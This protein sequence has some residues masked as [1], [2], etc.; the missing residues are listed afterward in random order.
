MKPPRP[1]LFAVLAVSFAVTACATPPPDFHTYRLGEVPPS[2]R[3]AK[4]K[5]HHPQ[6]Q[7]KGQNTT[8]SASRQK[9]PQTVPQK[10]PLV[11]W[12]MFKP[13]SQPTPASNKRSV[14]QNT[15]ARPTP[16][17]NKRAV[18][19][20]SKTKPAPAPT[21]A[22][23]AQNTKAR[24]QP[25]P[26]LVTTKRAV[27]G[28][29]QPQPA[30]TPSRQQPVAKNSRTST[31]P[32]AAQNPQPPARRDHPERAQARSAAALKYPTAKKTMQDGYVTS[33]YTH[34]KINV[35]RVP[36]GAQV[37]DPSSEKVFINP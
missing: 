18:T 10:Q 4:A 28:N 36:H 32:I 5:K 22:A 13:E 23:V 7:H 24:P 34:A 12:W 11:R 25:T 29:K 14:A 2:A 15:K 35:K 6:Q 21:K 3:E 9:A 27:F 17:P 16:A 26:A 8:A 19:Q 33:P 37:L 1:V 20:I 31:P 30:P